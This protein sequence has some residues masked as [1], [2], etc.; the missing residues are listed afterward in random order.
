MTVR[1]SLG[2]LFK[3]QRN[4]AQAIGGNVTGPNAVHSFYNPTVSGATGAPIFSS[5]TG[6][7]IQPTLNVTGD[8]EQA[9]AMDITPVYNLNGFTQHTDGISPALHV[10][11]GLG[12]IRI[13]QNTSYAG[14]TGQPLFIYQGSGADKEEI[15]NY[16]NGVPT[17]RAFIWHLDNRPV[18][19]AN[20]VIPALRSTLAPAGA[21]A[22]SGVSFTMDRYYYATEASIEMKYE[23]SPKGDTASTIKT[24]IAFN[25][26][27]LGVHNTALYISGAK[28]GMGT[29]TPSAQ[30]HTT[31][32]VRFAGLTNDNTQTRILVA[33]ASGNLYYRDASTIAMNDLPGASFVA[34]RQ[35]AWPADKEAALLKRI[36]T[37]TRCILEQEQKIHALEEQRQEL[38]WIKKE[39]KAL[40]Q[41]SRQRPP[42]KHKR[43]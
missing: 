37:M 43:K 19:V 28:I 29:T 1:D 15:L 38:D 21:V 35:N 22:G 39:L 6:M 3:I 26:T 23:L 33:D 17:T 16:R 4:G 20:A 9:Y 25:T 36:E 31:G 34:N 18:T 40:Q 41:K 30:L 10:S 24:G 13:D 12:G 14:N 42:A 32:N 5:V 27:D 11:S 2:D 8:Y 7:R